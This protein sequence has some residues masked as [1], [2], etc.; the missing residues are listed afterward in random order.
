[1]EYFSIVS[2]VLLVK[3]SIRELLYS[4]AS[5]SFCNIVE[6]VLDKLCLDDQSNRTRGK[7]TVDSVLLSSSAAVSMT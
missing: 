4:I 7:P 1:M 5:V 6:N 3:Q 2:L